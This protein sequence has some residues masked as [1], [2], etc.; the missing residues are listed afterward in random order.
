MSSNDF[1]VFEEKITFEVINIGKALITHGMGDI[2]EEIIAYTNIKELDLAKNYMSD[3][4]SL[5]IEVCNISHEYL[6]SLFKSISYLNHI[7]NLYSK[8]QLM[9]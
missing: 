1:N 8:T 6:N 3:N 4:K 5:I 2:G 9:N 7:D